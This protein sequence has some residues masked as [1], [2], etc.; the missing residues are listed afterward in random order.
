MIELKELSAEDERQVYTK[1]VCIFFE[2]RNA[3]AEGRDTFNSNSYDDLP[4][5][6][7]D[8]RMLNKK[9]YGDG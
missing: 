9:R 4:Y 5:K 3:D 1:L 6:Y 7:K 2:N 8:I